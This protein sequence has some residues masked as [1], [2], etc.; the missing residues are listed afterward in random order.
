MTHFY[1]IILTSV[2][3]SGDRDVSGL[4]FVSLHQRQPVRDGLTGN[5]HTRRHKHT[6]SLSVFITAVCSFFV[7]SFFLIQKRDEDARRYGNLGRHTHTH[8]A[9][10]INP[11][12]TCRRSSCIYLT[13]SA[14]FLKRFACRLFVFALS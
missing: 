9:Y 7:F 10:C 5:T 6:H 11:N 2:S 1:D 14:E 13:S 8:R 12:T 3:V 4:L